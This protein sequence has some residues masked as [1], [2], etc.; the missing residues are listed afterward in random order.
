MASG[1]MD[2]V[3]GVP[4][5][6]D[7]AVSGDLASRLAEWWTNM[8]AREFYA[9]HVPLFRQKPVRR[10]A[11]VVRDLTNGTLKRQMV[12][13]HRQLLGGLNKMDHESELL[14]KFVIAPI[15]VNQKMVGD[16]TPCTGMLEVVGSNP[17]KFVPCSSQVRAAARR[18]WPP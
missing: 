11:N 12:R 13:R 1:F 16:G 14:P 9:A 18:F 4:V 15:T 5:L 7:A 17:P 6:Y 2:R 8:F 10:L 3:F